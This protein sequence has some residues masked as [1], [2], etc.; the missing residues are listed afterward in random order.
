MDSTYYAVSEN[1]ESGLS[2][3]SDSYT[4]NMRAMR[5]VTVRNVTETWLSSYNGSLLFL[6][7]NESL[8]DLYIENPDTGTV[9]SWFSNAAQ[10]LEVGSVSFSNG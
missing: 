8:Y 9:D 1:G 5:P 3:G 6:V 4:L 2:I 10:S 7:K